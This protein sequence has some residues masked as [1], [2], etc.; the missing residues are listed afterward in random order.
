MKNDAPYASIVTQVLEM[1]KENLKRNGSLMP[2][3]LFMKDSRI[4]G[5]QPI[6]WDTDAEKWHKYKIIGA[7]LNKSGVDA[8]IVVSDGAMRMMNNLSKEQVEYINQNLSTEAPLTL[9][10]GKLGRRE[11][12]TV[13]YFDPSQNLS[14]LAIQASRYEGTDRKIV[15]E[16]RL[17]QTTKAEGATYGGAIRDSVFDGYEHADELLVEAAS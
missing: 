16:E 8:V 12:V 5:V 2:V 3:V 1:A 15:F 6:T 9:P 4:A 7:L 10:E 14:D 11:C 17:D 13:W